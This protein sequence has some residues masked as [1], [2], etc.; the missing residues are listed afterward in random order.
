Q[1]VLVRVRLAGQASVVAT[2]PK[3][4]AEDNILMWEVGTLLPKQEK[5]LSM[6][7][8][9]PARGDVAAQAWV[10]FT[11]SSAM[12]LKVR[13]P[14]LVVKATAPPKLM[15]GDVATFALEVTNPGDGTAEQVKLHADL[16]EGLEHPR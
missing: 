9:T 1:Q 5:N 3:A 7:L 13:E 14:K 8:L 2:E 15:V 12:R 11:G 4:A 16:G 10:T 6:R